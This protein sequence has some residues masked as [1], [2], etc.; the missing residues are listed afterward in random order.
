MR[1]AIVEDDP[2]Q[3]ELVERVL[4]D[5]G[6]KTHSFR[7]GRDFLREFSRE[8]FDLLV[9]DWRL[10]DVPGIEI[11]RAV[12]SKP[13]AQVG[14]MFATVRDEEADVIEAFEAGAD[15]YMTKP[16]R[17]GE[18][19]VRL[20]ALMRRSAT[21]NPATDVWEF[22]RFRFDTARSQAWNRDQPVALTSKEFQLGM[23]LLRNIGRPLSRGH[24]RESVWGNGSD[25]PTRTL[26]THV[27]RVRSK[28][29]LRPDE[30]YLLAPVYSYGYRL[31]RLADD[32]DAPAVANPA[33]D[34]E[35][36][37]PSA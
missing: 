8:S 30:G 3:R 15:D 33:F 18:L 25:L 9:V 5:A 22:D 13:N 10:P 19:V 36:V 2:L 35:P 29:G 1:V 34:D 12:R 31:E 16:V 11:V 4:S 28:L 6:F 37:L 17:T 21:V 20:R 23:L 32:A 24:L 26:D 7:S 27:S 14:I